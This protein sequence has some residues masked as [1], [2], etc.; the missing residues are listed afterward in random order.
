MNLYRTDVFNTEAHPF[1]APPAK[2]TYDMGVSAPTPAAPFP[3]QQGV[4]PVAQI[5]PS[6][7][8]DDSLTKTIIEVITGIVGGIFEG[9]D[10]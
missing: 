9:S 1:R 5:S 4:P 3:V 10:P 8:L 7:L 6:P 2:S